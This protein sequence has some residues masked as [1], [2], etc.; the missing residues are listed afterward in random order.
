MKNTLILQMALLVSYVT[1]SFSG[2]F[3]GPTLVEQT[4]T[5]QKASFPGGTEKMNAWIKENL[6]T[7]KEDVR[8]GIVRVEFTVKKSGML[9]NFVIKKGLNEGMDFSAI[10]CL[11]GMPKWNP[12]IKNGKKTNQKQ[13]LPIKFSSVD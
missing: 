7:P 10:E 6:R 3:E 5:D 4:E 2:N 8:Y 13:T 11:Q 9:T 1:V 12:A